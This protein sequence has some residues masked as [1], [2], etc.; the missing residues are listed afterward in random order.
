[1]GWRTL[2]AAS[3]ALFLVAG[4]AYWLWPGPA[5]AVR[6]SSGFDALAIFPGGG[7]LALASGQGVSA[8]F[9]GTTL[10]WSRGL[11]G[12][13][14][15]LSF[16]PRGD[17]VAAF[18]GD[19]L[20]FMSVR[21]GSV[22]REARLGLSCAPSS[23]IHWSPSGSAVLVS[24]RGRVAYVTLGGGAEVSPYVG[25]T[26][27]RV[28]WVSDSEVIIVDDLGR[29][30]YVLSASPLTIRFI[31]SYGVSGSAGFFGGEVFIISSR[32]WASLYGPGGPEYNVSLGSPV[33]ASAVSALGFAVVGGEALGIDPATGS[34]VWRHGL[35]ISGEGVVGLDACGDEVAVTSAEVTGGEVAYRTQVLAGGA[36]LL[37]G[38]LPGNGTRFLAWFG[39]CSR[40]LL[41]RGE[42][43]YVVDLVG[44]E[45][46]EVQEALTPVAS[47]GES[48]IVLGAGAQS[49]PYLLSPNASL[50]PLPRLDYSYV[51]PLSNGSVV[52]AGADGVWL[53]RLSQ[54][55][56]VEGP[57]LGWLA[58]AAAGA[59]LAG[60]AY[61]KRV[62]GG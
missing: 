13:V 27:T 61:K 52:V 41:Q 21:D 34:I 23:L 46:V 17:L 31:A 37:Q 22:V 42:R 15:A 53:V 33:R 59:A 32:G 54:P 47:V 16:S 1:M 9:A 39:N 8:Y 35:G 58:P 49:V 40:A 7:M 60:L 43:S 28:S 11:G 36:N 29:A 6:L 14:C 62:K 24:A 30:A 50:K 20:Y 38:L 18:A 26:A 45:V 4:L 2:A 10:A 19:R 56:E 55:V 57:Y 48:M 5:Q 51:M 3:L 25:I 12:D 44:R